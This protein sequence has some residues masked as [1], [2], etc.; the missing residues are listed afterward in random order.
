M[1]HFA[2]ELR[3][4]G[5]NVDYVKLD[6]LYNT[7]S[8]TGEAGRAI[9]R[10][11]ATRMTIGMSQFADGGLLA[12]KPYA[13]SGAYIDRMSDFCKQ[14]HYDVKQTSG[15]DACRFNY[16]Y[17]AFLIRNQKRL[18]HNPRLAMAYR[19]LKAMPRGRT[20][21]ILHDARRFAGSLRQAQRQASNRQCGDPS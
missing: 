4:D 5:V 2:N 18:Q 6:D 1:R 16:L 13:A 15:S 3:N 17:W 9:E 14:C 7:G 20:R 21:Q 19:Q 12:S 11:R 8:F 10:H